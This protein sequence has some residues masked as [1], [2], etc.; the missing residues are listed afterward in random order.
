MSEAQ[1]ELIYDG[2]AVE[3]G[4]MDVRELAPALLAVGHLC[5]HANRLAN[6]DRNEI[7]VSVKSEIKTGSFD[8]TILLKSAD[9]VVNAGQLL[10]STQPITA[11]QLLADIGLALG[12]QV[13]LITLIQSVGTKKKPDE[14]IT[15]QDGNVNLIFSGKNYTVTA[16]T[17]YL[18]Q[19]ADAV[20][21][22][23][24][25]VEPL[26]HDGFTAFKSRDNGQVVASIGR[27]DIDRFDIAEYE[28]TEPKFQ[29]EADTILELVKP[30]FNKDL[31]WLFWDG[32]SNISTDIADSKFLEQVED[33]QVSF[34]K[35]DMFTVRLLTRTWDDGGTLRTRRTVLKV[36]S[37]EKTD[38]Q[39]TLF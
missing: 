29:T 19:N 9:L 36:I 16:N 14:V 35:G 15:L 34:T 28:S 3:G 2:P 8:L 27:D 24:E 33:H 32:Q 25:M 4:I 37:I 17:Y 21:S 18:Y 30:S 7:S 20:E 5:E 31:K 13:S 1:V 10:L 23:R 22:V 11:H 39:I 12:I 26:H 6:G 38:R